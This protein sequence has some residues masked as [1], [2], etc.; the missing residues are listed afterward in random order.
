MEN[1]NGAR[2]VSAELLNDGIVIKFQDG[3]CFFYSA[4]VLLEMIPQAKELDESAVAW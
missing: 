4:S 1:Q 2:V 3:R